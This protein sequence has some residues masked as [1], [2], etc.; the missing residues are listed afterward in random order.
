MNSILQMNHRKVHPKLVSLVV[1]HICRTKP[2][3]QLNSSYSICHI[4][5]DFYNI[6]Y[7]DD[8][9]YQMFTHG[10][11]VESVSKLASN[12]SLYYHICVLI[13]FTQHLKCLRI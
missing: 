10:I 1:E 13:A 4:I 8:C 11:H 6:F 3:C 12:S 9:F 2:V 7:L 5:L